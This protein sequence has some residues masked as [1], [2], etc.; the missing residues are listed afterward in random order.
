MMNAVSV[1]AG[2][3]II[4]LS[5][6]AL[7]RADDRARIIDD[8]V[9][10]TGASRVTAG[11]VINAIIEFMHDLQNRITY[12]A[13]SDVELESKKVAARN[14]VEECFVSGQSEVQIASATTGRVRTRPV[15]Q[16][17]FE[18]SRLRERYGYTK[19]ELYFLSDYLGVGRVHPLGGRQYELSISSDQ[20]FIAYK[21]ERRA[22]FD[23]TTKQFR[24]RFTLTND[25]VHVTVNEI[26][27]T[28]VVKDP[29]LRSE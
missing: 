8:I 24:V 22:Y 9:A 21:N 15:E 27:V 23:K 29:Q 6:S 11:Q 13:S 3:L 12:I 2:A 28:E 4:V 20:I 16:Y 5:V 10:N 7:V 19:V 17:F 26:L 14:A 1:R 25:E 18:L